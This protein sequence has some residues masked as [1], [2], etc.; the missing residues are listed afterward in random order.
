MQI[1]DSKY[2]NKIYL[3][4]NEHRLEVYIMLYLSK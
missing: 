3:I 4:V 1:H 2:F